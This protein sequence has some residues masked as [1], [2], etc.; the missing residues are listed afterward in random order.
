[1]I[2]SRHCDSFVT[3]KLCG[4]TVFELSLSLI[5]C[6]SVILLFKTSKHS[7]GELKSETQLN[8]RTPLHQRFHT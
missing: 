3:L 7:V 1:M 8:L 2:H 5:S 6:V 4:I